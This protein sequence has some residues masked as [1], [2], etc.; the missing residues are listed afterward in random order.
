MR[1]FKKNHVAERGI[2]TQVR[3]EFILRLSI[4]KKVILGALLAGVVL[5]LA[6][7]ALSIAG[8]QPGL[9]ADDPFVEIISLPLFIE[10]IQPDGSAAMVTTQNKLGFFNMQNFPKI[11]PANTVRIFCLGGSTTY[12]NPYR[13]STSFCGWLREMLPVA[14]P[15][16]HWEL[17][18]AGGISYASYREAALMEEL[19]RY[20]PDV[21]IDLSGQNEFLEERSYGS[22]RELPVFVLNGVAWLARTHI[23]S[24]VKQVLP[25]A[26]FINRNRQELQ[27]EVN[28]RLAHTIGPQDY[29][30]DDKLARQIV[31]HFEWNLQRKAAIARAAGAR[32]I[33]V[34]PPVNMKDI[35]PFKS[36]HRPDMTA[37][38]L[39]HWAELDTRGQEAL[40]RG[41][42]DVAA[43]AFRAALKLDNRY[44]H[45]HFQ[46]GTALLRQGHYEEAKRAFQH[47]IDEDICPLR[48]L[49]SLQN[50]IQRI[51]T[52]QKIPLVN[53]IDIAAA[54]SQ[55]LTG[56]A[57]PGNELFLDHVHPTI[58]GN[59]LLALALMEALNQQG[60]AHFDAGWNKANQEQ[61]TQKVLG[62]LNTL[63]HANALQHLGRLFGWAGKL[64]EAHA[65]LLRA[66]D[67]FG[68]EHAGTL[69]LLARSSERRGKL[70]EAIAYQSRINGF[71]DV[72]RLYEKLGHGNEAAQAYGQWVRSHPEDAYAHTLYASVLMR[73]GRYAEAEKQWTRALQLDPKLYRSRGELANLYVQEGRYRDGIRE[74]E[75]LLRQ[76]P[77][78]YEADYNIAL[79]FINTGELTPAI[80][81]LRHALK[82]RPDLIAAHIALG[83][84]LEK[85]GQAEQAASEY[86]R[87]LQLDPQSVEA[88][89]NLGTYLA[90]KGRRAEA[91]QHFQKAILI[92]PDFAPARQ[93]LA[94]TSADQHHLAD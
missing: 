51:A 20:Q 32:M 71:G 82:I 81:H 19:S 46:L 10:R 79:A 2:S 26:G 58:E 91:I 70:E 68:T 16:R 85:Q 84:A 30:R 11:K 48:A 69:A 57:I 43:G 13:D 28:E 33:M 61:I 7:C 45:T 53:F 29:H 80:E 77:G 73:L 22:V 42:P 21:F 72:G 6:E 52:E 25:T 60:A 63:D 37:A 64:D 54:E 34:T 87:A 35:S 44:A 55:R 83:T 41:A 39:A 49:S 67:M 24:A 9:A 36:E 5:A 88:L 15:T 66:L 75:M 8:V 4:W 50:A 18:N 3:T 12:G 93:N 92:N 47:A 40:Q 1:F 74:Y 90:H 17:I 89:N 31:Q 38:Q 76:Q 94:S 78:N 65:L 14:D 27:P 56:H 23:Y 86:R 62:Q 59:R